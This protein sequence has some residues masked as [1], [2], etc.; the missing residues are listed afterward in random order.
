MVPIS[1]TGYLAGQSWSGPLLVPPHV[2]SLVVGTGRYSGKLQ[3]KT[4]VGPTKMAT[5]WALNHQLSD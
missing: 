3:G 2:A 4:L 5:S 1:G